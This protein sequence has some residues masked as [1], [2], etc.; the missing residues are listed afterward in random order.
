MAGN[1][2][3]EFDRRY[4]VRAPDIFIS[5]KRRER[6][7][8]AALASAL[9]RFGLDV[10]FDRRL[11]IGAPFEPEIE[12][13]AQA[14]RAMIV[15]WTAACMERGEGG[16]Q[17]WVLREAMIGRER[18]VLAPV[19][20]EPAA[21]LP[22]ESPFLYD[23]IEPLDHWVV[24]TGPELDSEGEHGA[25]NDPAFVK[26]LHKLGEPELIDRPGLADLAKV[27]AALEEAGEPNHQGA[28]AMLEKAA[29]QG[30]DWLLNFET[31][32]GAERLARELVDYE[33]AALGARMGEEYGRL[34]GD[35]TPPGA[36]AMRRER[37][38]M[39]E[40]ERLR[41]S[42][43]GLIAHRDQLIQR[44]TALEAAAAAYQAQTPTAPQPVERSL[45]DELQKT[46]R[47]VAASPRSAGER[48]SSPSLSPREGEV[49][50]EVRVFNGHEIFRNAAIEKEESSFWGLRSR[51]VRQ[52]DN[53][54]IPARVRAVAFFPDSDQFLTA[55]ND[56]RLVVWRQDSQQ[57]VLEIEAS[58]ACDND[59]DGGVYSAA[60]SPDGARIATGDWHDGVTIWDSASGEQIHRLQI[61]RSIVDSVA[62]APDGAKIITSGMDNKAR[63]WDVV[64]GELLRRLEERSDRI[65]T[66]DFAA[67][68][69]RVLTVGSD[70]AVSVWD[71]NSGAE[72]HRLV[73]PNRVGTACFVS[74]RGHLI[75]SCD[76]ST[77]HIWDAETGVET[78]TLPGHSNLILALA[79]DARG[80]RLASGD[81]RGAVNIW[82]IEGGRRVA[83]LEAHSD[84][85][86]TVAFDATGT[87]LLTGSNDGAARLWELEA[88]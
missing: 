56:G 85:V 66:V 44:M 41:R 28:R 50:R 23:H 55:G 52:Q 64:K 47:A 45:Q 5:Y 13:Y 9:E 42:E 37:G 61:P 36:E 78:R 29:R 34:L 74:K 88:A 14:C 67:E 24:A 43:Q 19:A 68:G 57:P 76:L 33:Y 80:Q 54:S 6:P 3:F 53:K 62:F 15:C 65:F 73:H 58:Q 22:L 84:N 26:L 83:S 25:L 60:I 17:S 86:N 12:A 48:R 71:A 39:F 11:E 27:Y 70:E 51:K 63:I 59:G 16:E 1:N 4:L 40:I 8:V 21:D 7:R 32:P 49:W 87:R 18:G 82:D 30:R 38:M 81:Y 72:L 35:W 10:W 77:I 2:E 75:A 20:L 46:E 79:A 69:D 31:D